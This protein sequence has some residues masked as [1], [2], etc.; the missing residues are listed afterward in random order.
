[1]ISSGVMAYDGLV[2][3]VGIYENEPKIFTDDEGNAAGFWPELILYIADQEGWEIEWVHGTWTEC[4]ERLERNE[5]DLMPDVAYTEERDEL[6]D[7]SLE[8][9]YV[10]WSR[11]YSQESI[12]INSILDLEGKTIA[13]LEGSINFV[14]PDG[15][16]K[17][18]EAFEVKCTFI[19]VDSYLEVF[20]MIDNKEVDAGIVSKDF[21]YQHKRDFNV[22]ET[23]II[24]QPTFLYFAFPEESALKPVLI[25]IIDNDMREL[26]EDGESIFYQALK[27]WIG[28]SPIEKPVFPDWVKWLLIGVGSVVLIFVGGTLILRTRVSKKTKELRESEE[29][30]R[31]VLETLPHGL[32]VLDLEGRIIQVNRA[33]LSMGSYNKEDSVGKLYLDFVVKKDREKAKRNLKNTL[34][35]GF[36]AYNEYNL[37]RKNG[38]EFPA[39]IHLNLIKDPSGNPEGFVAVVED[40]TNV[41]QAEDDKRKVHE[42]EEL[43][44]LRTH[45]LST[46]SHELR[47]PLASIKGYATLL[48]DYYSKLKKAQKWETLEAIDQSTDRLTELIEHLLDMSRLDAGLLRLNFETVKPEDIFMAAVEEAKL[49][50]P[51]YKFKAKIDDPM[52]KITA[53]ARR[54]RQITDNLL[55]NAVKYSAESTKITLE[56]IVQPQKIQISVT[57]QGRGIP[58]DEISRI[59]DRFYRLEERLEKDPGGLGLGLS[60]CKSLV[61]AHGGRIWVE[62]NAGQGS[63]FYFTIPINGSKKS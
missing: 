32:V 30:L 16:K 6:Y 19:P 39:R 4:L 42:Y 53:D 11:V 48:L 37:L 8:P 45:L 5:I 1:M 20:Q 55:D 27:E 3:R 24:F 43:D 7:F 23:S 10:S 52:P 22:V 21:A 2:V 58:A 51:K 44:K 13:V 41:K 40:I 35:I 47:T 36:S 63:T 54:L 57:D 46:V 62:T 60:L 38:E 33:V 18:A 61:E 29:K 31:L 26:K 49:R 59:F 56:A 15:I 17:L 9:V 12:N 25:S 28:A 14:G 50:S 34:E